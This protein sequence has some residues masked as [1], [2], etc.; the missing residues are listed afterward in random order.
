LFIFLFCS[1]AEH[2]P[3]GVRI[4]HGSLRLWR[5]TDLL[6]ASYA[7]STAIPPSINKTTL[8]P[9]N[10][11]VGKLKTKPFVTVPELKLHLRS[12]GARR[13]E[14]SARID[15]QS[16]PAGRLYSRASSL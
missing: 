13:H 3:S 4:K 16:T 15:R 14:E 2:G 8:L 7:A 1:S 6:V 9:A 12:R 5:R 11:K 10:F